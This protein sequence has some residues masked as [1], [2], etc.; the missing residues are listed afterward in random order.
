[1][2]GERHARSPSTRADGKFEENRAHKQ[3]YFTLIHPHSDWRKSGDG[4]KT[5]GT[6]RPKI[7][8]CCEGRTAL[9]RQKTG[10]EESQNNKDRKEIQD[11]KKRRRSEIRRLLRLRQSGAIKKEAPGSSYAMKAV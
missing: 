8:F 6:E 10:E 2:G 1:M 11:R 7:L 9:G 3:A 4:E 5:N